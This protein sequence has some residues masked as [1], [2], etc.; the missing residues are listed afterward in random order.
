MPG[1]ASPTAAKAAFSS[2]EFVRRNTAVIVSLV[3]PH[4]VAPPL[5]PL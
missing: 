3:T 2:A 1:A 4:D 5:L